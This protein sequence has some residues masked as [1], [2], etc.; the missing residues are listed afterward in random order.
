MLFLV[1]N[2]IDISPLVPISPDNITPVQVNS[3]T[4]MP[5]DYNSNNDIAVIATDMRIQD[6]DDNSEMDLDE[7]ITPSNEIILNLLLE[8]KEEMKIT[9]QEIHNLKSKKEVV[10]FLQKKEILLILQYLRD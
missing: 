6:F 9:S 4:L 7:P 8:L 2:L 1:S 5:H 10:I 3:V